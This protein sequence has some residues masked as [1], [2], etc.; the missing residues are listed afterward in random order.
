MKKC[1]WIF[2]FLLISAPCSAEF[3][4][5]R[6][7][8]GAIR[9][10]DDLSLVPEDQR[11]KASG[12]SEVKSSTEETS[13]PASE[14]AEPETPVQDE[15]KE[16]MQSFDAEAKHLDAMRAELEKEYKALGSGSKRLIYVFKYV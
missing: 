2:V 11:E 10:T 7:E 6:D 13:D 4:K 12:Y 3:Y 16:A 9:F 14:T 1:V 8:T 5:Y 15:K